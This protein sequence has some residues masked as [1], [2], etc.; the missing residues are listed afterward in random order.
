MVSVIKQPTCGVGAGP[1]PKAEV[2]PLS[3]KSESKIIKPSLDVVEL[4]GLFVGGVLFIPE[5]CP[6][7]P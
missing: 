4:K 6:T 3:K 2:L 7:E 1:T 5:Y